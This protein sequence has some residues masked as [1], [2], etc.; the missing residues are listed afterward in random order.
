MT[1]DI[2][3]S[4]KIRFSKFFLRILISEI[5][6][7]IIILLIYTLLNKTGYLLF[8]LSVF[9]P[10]RLLS[11]GVH[12]YTYFRCLLF[13]ILYFFL[14]TFFSHFGLSQIICLFLLGFGFLLYAFS[15]PL[16]NP[17]RDSIKFTKNNKNKYATLCIYLF[18]MICYFFLKTPYNNLC[19]YTL[20]FGS[21]QTL[22]V[23]RK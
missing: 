21:L 18:W 4:F 5:S 6:K 1:E 23:R 7:F 2:N 14:I 3:L 15:L 13:T 10:I 8:I 9:L 17:I 11:G 22:F 12:F 16:P 20:L 19:F